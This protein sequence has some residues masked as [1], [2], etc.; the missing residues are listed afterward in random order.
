MRRYTE[1]ELEALLNWDG[2]HCKP[3]FRNRAEECQYYARFIERMLW[4]Y[5]TPDDWRR[6]AEIIADVRVPEKQ[7][8][9]TLFLIKRHITPPG[10]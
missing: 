9:A 5:L 1:R 8:K 7:K 6:L 10:T 4:R 3:P 2:L